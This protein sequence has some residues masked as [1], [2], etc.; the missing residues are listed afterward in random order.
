MT[1][2]E[3]IKNNIIILEHDDGTFFISEINCSIGNVGGNVRGYVDGYVGGDVRGYVGGDVG[4]D[5]RGYVGG[6][7][8]YDVG[9]S[10]GGSVYGDVG[11]D[12]GS[13]GGSVGQKKEQG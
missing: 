10:V 12:V 2:E 1:K 9:G 6:D 5:V 13:V 8:R 3:F 7:V 4:G 11:G